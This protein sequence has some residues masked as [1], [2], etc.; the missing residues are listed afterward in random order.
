MECVGAT[1]GFKM[2]DMYDSPARHWPAGC[3]VQAVQRVL[4]LWLQ[5]SQIGVCV[6]VLSHIV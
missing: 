3:P 4:L 2:S 5:A 1:Y 6:R